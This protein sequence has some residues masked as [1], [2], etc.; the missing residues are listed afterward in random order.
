MSMKR[1][2]ERPTVDLVE[3]EEKDIII[4][5]GELKEN[6]DQTLDNDVDKF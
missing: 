4:T 1:T 3:L 5:S 6:W 2:Y